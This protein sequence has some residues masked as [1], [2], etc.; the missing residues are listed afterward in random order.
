MSNTST[1][2]PA[3]TSEPNSNSNNNYSSH[4]ELLA[5]YRN[6][7]DSLAENKDSISTINNR[8]LTKNREFQIATDLFLRDLEQIERLRITA[9]FILICI[10]FLGLVYLNILPK[11][12]GYIIIS[13]VLIAYIITVIFIHNNFHKRYNLNFALYHYDPKFARYDPSEAEND[14][15]AT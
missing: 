8:T 11:T 12:L 15:C 1:F 5:Y 2:A 13:A 9:I 7:L 14:V 3:S 4:T 6:K 10:G